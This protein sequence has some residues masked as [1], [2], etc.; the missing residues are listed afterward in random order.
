MGL[1]D[2]KEAANLFATT[3]NGLNLRFD[4]RIVRGRRL[5]DD[6]APLRALGE[7]AHASSDL[8]ELTALRINYFKKGTGEREKGLPRASFQRER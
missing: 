6:L 2:Q 5:E 8:A 7:R 4:D 1:R 3:E